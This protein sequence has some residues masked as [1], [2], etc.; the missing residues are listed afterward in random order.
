MNRRRFIKLL[1]ASSYLSTFRFA[2]AEDAYPSRTIQIIVPFAAGGSVDISARIVA[3]FLYEEL[4][5][6]VIVENRAGAAGRVGAEAVFRSPADGYT[7]L[8]GSS[9]SLT[10]LEAVSKTLPYEVERDFVPVAQ[11]N[12]TPM[13]II[14]GP[15]S[16]V[17]SFDELIKAAKAEP[18]AITVASAG[19]GSS[20]HLAIELIQLKFGIKFLHIPYKGSGQALTDVLAGH[21]PLMV[22]QIASSIGYIRGNQLTAIAVMSP[23]RSSQL[24][25]VPTLDE[26]SKQQV[27]ASS[28][29]GI[30]AR[31]GTPPKILARLEQAIV[32]VASRPDV[33]KRFEELGADPRVTNAADFAEYI[34]ADL[35]RWKDVAQK[36]DIVI[37]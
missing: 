5:Q 32:K 26:L 1:G 25:E 30:L 2:R 27:E 29:T 13:A 23:T 31:S 21:I 20:N 24:P 35:G 3:N 11:L 19:I 28:F 17:H 18:G 16:K 14:A 12:V 7:L 8:A 10:A 4:G 15:G 22:D 37:D 33:Q 36:A 34:R 6:S 9:G